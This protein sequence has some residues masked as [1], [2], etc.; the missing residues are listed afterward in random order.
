MSPSFSHV[1]MAT[2]RPRSVFPQRSR[3]TFLW[4]Q[5]LCGAASK[6]VSG[7]RFPEIGRGFS[8]FHVGWCWAPALT[9]NLP[10]ETPRCFGLGVYESRVYITWSTI[11]STT[12]RHKEKTSHGVVCA[13]PVRA[14]NHIRWTGASTS[15]TRQTVWLWRWMNMR[16]TWHLHV[17]QWSIFR[18]FGEREDCVSHEIEKSSYEMPWPQK[19]CKYWPALQHNPQQH[20]PCKKSTNQ[21]CWRVGFGGILWNGDERN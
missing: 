7:R 1:A 12:D 2:L 6:Q 20:G 10:I 9:N 11:G 15:V 18:F 17:S 3:S 13:L 4:R 21:I 16:W 19:R 8:W 14:M 5:E